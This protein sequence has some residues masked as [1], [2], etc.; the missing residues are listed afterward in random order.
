M[1][2]VSSMLRAQVDRNGDESVFVNFEARLFDEKDLVTLARANFIR[3]HVTLLKTNCTRS[4]C[5]R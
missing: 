4:I 3:I 1:D 5:D 2:D